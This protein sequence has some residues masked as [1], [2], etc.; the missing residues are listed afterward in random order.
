MS[1]RW[2]LSPRQKGRRRVGW[3]ARGR[4]V[5]AAGEG[6]G[7]FLASAA[8]GP[9]W[10]GTDGQQDG[11]QPSR[12]HPGLEGE[13]QS[14]S[15]RG[16]TREGERQARWPRAR[17]PRSAGTRRAGPTCLTLSPR[18]RARGPGPGGTQPEAAG[19]SLPE[20]KVAEG[21]VARRAN[22]RGPSTANT[23]LYR[24]AVRAPQQFH[25]AKGER[26]RR[27]TTGAGGRRSPGGAPAGGWSAALTPPSGPG[28]WACPRSVAAF[29][30]SLFPSWGCSCQTAFSE[31]THP[32]QEHASM[33]RAR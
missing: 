25:P 20:Q 12:R 22:R 19:V 31:Q 1:Q 29:K 17:Q 16:R 28:P 5:S 24:N 3:C 33:I 8:S 21:P 15:S 6:P 23:C 10:V 4:R 2:A 13:V 18:L 30:N 7:G 14:P 9:A 27:R 11:Q 32:S 26:E